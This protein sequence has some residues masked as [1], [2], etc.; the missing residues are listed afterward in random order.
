M[1]YVFW[2]FALLCS[3]QPPAEHAFLLKNDNKFCSSR[4]M[5]Y[6]C[7]MISK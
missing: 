4:S 2:F 7:N 3:P 5:K 1:Y 6:L